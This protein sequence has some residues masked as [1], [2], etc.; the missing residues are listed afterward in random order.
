MELRRAEDE[1]GW[2]CESARLA[3]YI[4]EHPAQDTVCDKITDL[5]RY[6]LIVAQSLDSIWRRSSRRRIRL[7]L[8]QVQPGGERAGV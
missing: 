8:G 3:R 4:G 6:H 2:T 7:V 1:P 5:L